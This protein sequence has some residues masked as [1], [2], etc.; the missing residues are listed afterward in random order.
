M[1]INNYLITVILFALTAGGGTPGKTSGKDK[2]CRPGKKGREKRVTIRGRIAEYLCGFIKSR[3]EDSLY[4]FESVV[5][6]EL[7]HIRRETGTCYLL[8]DPEI[9]YSIRCSGTDLLHYAV[10]RMNRDFINEFVKY[11]RINVNI[12]DRRGYTIYDY[13]DLTTN[14]IVTIL[15][16]EKKSARRV[17]LQEE[18]LLWNKFKEYLID[19]FGAKPCRAVSEKMRRIKKCPGT[20]H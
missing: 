11:Y 13:A 15:K 17:A 4:K 18:I 5:I 3:G 9:Y 7:E 8:T 12:Q 1:K 2:T 16:R 20:G 14:E 6:K 19:E 10:L